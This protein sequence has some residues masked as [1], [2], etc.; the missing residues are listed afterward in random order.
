MTASAVVSRKEFDELKEAFEADRPN[1]KYLHEMHRQTEDILDTVTQ[2]RDDQKLLGTLVK[3]QG[4]A[5]TQLE[6]DVGT[7]KQDVGNLKQ[8]VV[9]LKQ[10]V[11]TLKQDVGTLKDDVSDIKDTLKLILNKLE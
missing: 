8:D 1:R 3:R 7:L 11:K 5:I 4:N 9:T 6:T 2:I 10:D